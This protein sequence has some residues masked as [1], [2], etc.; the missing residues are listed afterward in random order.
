[1]LEIVGVGGGLVALQ[2]LSTIKRGTSPFNNKDF[3]KVSRALA[4]LDA[5]SKQLKR[6]NQM[7]KKLKLCKINLKN[8]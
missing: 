1:V 2:S 5:A 7:A 4:M 6:S 8:F 3:I